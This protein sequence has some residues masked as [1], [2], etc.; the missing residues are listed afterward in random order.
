[1]LMRELK[2]VKL[3]H[4]FPLQSTYCTSCESHHQGMRCLEDLN[5]NVPSLL[6]THQIKLQDL[7]SPKLLVPSKNLE[8]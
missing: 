7:P 3:N 6:S 4:D 2:E 1:M 8:M 5:H